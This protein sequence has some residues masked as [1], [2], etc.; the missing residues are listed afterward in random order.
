[1]ILGEPGTAHEAFGVLPAIEAELSRFV[2]SLELPDNLVDAIAYSFL[3]GGKRLRPVLAWWSAVAAGASGHAGFPAGVALELVH[4]F[5]LVHDDLPAMDDDDLRRG[6]PTLHVHAGEAMAI[7]AGDAMLTLAYQHLAAQSRN[8]GWGSGGELAALLVAELASGTSGM[9]AGQVFDT[10][11]GM[12]AGMS[13]HGKVELIHL[14]KTAALITAACRMGAILGLAGNGK[15]PDERVLGPITGYARDIGLMFQIVD[16]LIDVEQPPEQAGKRTR[17]DSDA[18]KLTCPG[19]IGVEASRREVQR[20]CA[21]ARA[22]IAPL[23]NAA[24]GLEAL[25]DSLSVRTR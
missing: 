4:C 1:M 22:S 19:V 8:H 3:G 2:D 11:G 6:K 5:S 7:L 14:N 20:L 13:E 15:R 9:I 25:A 21:S 23:G 24:V 12:P 16:D 18:G 10:L 17:K